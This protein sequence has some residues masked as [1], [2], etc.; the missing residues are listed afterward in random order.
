MSLPPR[1]E[2]AGPLEE[3]FRSM[4]LASYAGRE[5]SENQYK[6]MHDTFF[7]GAMVLF[8]NLIYGM[9][10]SPADVVELPDLKLVESYHNELSGFVLD[11][12]AEAAFT[13]ALSELEAAERRKKN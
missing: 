2:Y 6:T 5:I 3:A 1:P 9:S 10:K 4:I 12:K 8:N 11:M 13:T 7:C